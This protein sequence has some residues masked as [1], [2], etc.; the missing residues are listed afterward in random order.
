MA[1]I[2]TLLRR[3]G[4]ITVRRTTSYC[5]T[6]R[7]SSPPPIDGYCHRWR[8]AMPYARRSGGGGGTRRGRRTTSCPRDVGVATKAPLPKK[9]G[10]GAN[11]AI[12]H[13]L[14]RVPDG[15]RQREVGCHHSGLSRPGTSPRTIS[16]SI[17]ME[18]RPRD[19]VP[20][21]TN[22]KKAP[23]TPD[24]LG[25]GHSAPRLRTFERRRLPNGAY[26][27]QFLERGSI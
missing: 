25:P 23:P 21:A 2:P 18:P 12:P 19:G 9:K 13:D 3:P 15:K 14:P 22:K 26:P 7:T 16:C 27:S 6:T 4:Y 10:W 24:H 20:E 11:P 17:G 1:Y 5:R 8:G